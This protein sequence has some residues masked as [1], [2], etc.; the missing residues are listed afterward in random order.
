MATKIATIDTLNREIRT[1]LKAGQPNLWSHG[2]GLCFS[3]AKNG[4]ATWV[5]RYTNADGRRRVMTLQAH[6]D[7]IGEREHKALE[8]RAIELRDAVKA[9]RDPLAVAKPKAALATATPVNETFE[10]A[11]RDYVKTHRADWK[12]DVHAGQWSRSLE[13]FV[14]PKLGKM[15]PHAISVDDVLAVLNQPHAKR[16]KKST[17]WLTVPETADRT[18][19]RVETVINA[20]KARALASND[21]DT[22]ARWINHHNP[23][24]WDILRH[25]LPKD[26]SKRGHHEAM[27]FADVPAFVQELRDRTDIP[28]KALL[29]TIL[30]ATRT[31]ET[32][33]ATWDEIDLE[34]GIWTIP[35][36]R[37]KAAQEHCIP[38]STTAIE[39]LKSLHRFQGHKYLF[40]GKHRHQPIGEMG[41]LDLLREMRPKQQLTVHGFR[42]SFRDL[43][44]ETTLHPDALVEMCLA[45][46]QR[47]KTV[48]AYKRGSAFERRKS[49]MEQWANYLTVANNNEY[50]NKW[51]RFIA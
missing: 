20:A 6:N 27:P 5:F 41:Q 48:A 9:G 37:M 40:P 10:Q 21:P 3:L 50:N 16:G 35:A 25:M 36:D 34:N 18:R 51:E 26:N 11:A 7:P 1:R 29:L 17:F 33:F 45:H 46:S 2:N 39:L 14:Y 31:S 44:A 28:A 47:D 24:S 8:L 4:K 12:S 19:Q 22:K 15:L 13:M 30:C 43:M 42:S 32:R 38:L 23:A 49:I